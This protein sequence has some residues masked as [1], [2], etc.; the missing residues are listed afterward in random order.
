L[1][2]RKEKGKNHGLLA[3]MNRLK[4]YKVEPKQFGKSFD[5][6]ESRLRAMYNGRFFLCGVFG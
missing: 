2:A 5:G 4:D 3:E 1:Q 6:H